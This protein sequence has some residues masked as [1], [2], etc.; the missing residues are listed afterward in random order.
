M[1]WYAYV[2]NDP[3]NRNDPS[4]LD[5]QNTGNGSAANP[6]VYEFNPG[7]GSRCA[8]GATCFT[9]DQLIGICGFS[10]SNQQAS[11][12]VNAYDPAYKQNSWMW[13]PVLAPVAVVMALEAPALISGM[14]RSGVEAPRVYNKR[15][16][17]IVRGLY[18]GTKNATRVGNGTT[19]AAVRNELETGLPT[20][21]TFHSLKAEQAISSLKKLMG[22]PQLSEW[23][24]QVA[25]KLL[26][27]LQNALK[28]F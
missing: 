12:Q 25:S 10:C 23:D 15:L 16:A 4:G 14:S 13:A 1:N 3:M 19:A 8:D 6:W 26:S 11:F 9:P 20:N 24:R 18:S 7:A 28:G 21:G 2:G 22:S 17:D 27:E 5:W